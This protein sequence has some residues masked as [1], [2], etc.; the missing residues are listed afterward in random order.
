MG[1]GMGLTVPRGAEKGGCCSFGV[2][3]PKEASRIYPNPFRDCC[4]WCQV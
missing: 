1:L 2:R 4:P 3:S